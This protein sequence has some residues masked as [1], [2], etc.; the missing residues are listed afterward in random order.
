MLFIVYIQN[1]LVLAVLACNVADFRR[2]AIEEEQR[3][4]VGVVSDLLVANTCYSFQN[5]FEILSR[6]WQVWASERSLDLL[7]R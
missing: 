6:P 1:S 3:L 2:V 7:A 5:W 4:M